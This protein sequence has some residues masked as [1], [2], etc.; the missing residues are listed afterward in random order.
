MFDV[1]SV[2]DVIQIINNNFIGYPL[3]NET[4]AL[5]D[6][7]GR[8]LCAD[9]LAHEEIPGFNRSS[10][11]GYAVISSDTFGASESLP[12]QLQLAGEIR[13]G[14]KPTVILQPGQAVYVPTGGE[15]PANADSVIMIE[16]TEDYQ[17]GFIYINKSSAPGNNVIFKGDD[18][19]IGDTVIKA[20]TVLRPQDIGAMA[21]MGYET[22]SVKQKVRVGV[23][24]TG[25][26]IIAISEKPQGSQ[27][28]DT[29]SYAL[30]AGLLKFGAVPT[31]YGIVKDNYDDIK[32]TVEKALH[33][34]DVI[35]IS[36][37][38]SVGTRDQS[39]KVINALG[40]PGI[41]V[42]GIAV[43]PGKPTILGKINGKAI[44]GLPGHPASAYTIFNIFVHHLLKVLTCMNNIPKTVVRVEMARNYPS[45]NG[46]EE[47][48]P[49]KLEEID[50]KYVAYPVFGKSGLITMLTAADG[51]V[52]IGRGCEGLDKGIQVDVIL[53]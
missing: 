45:N 29:N 15:L 42:H 41:L 2:N 33:Q 6:A 40:A 46:R 27:M 8:I 5:T 3:E 13:M 44:F 31:L 1:K 26:E 48:L 51:Y 24:S 20:G 43:K 17:D 23:I 28:R 25:D 38:S 7:L 52:H 22:I 16:Y 4:V 49:V 53:S 47:Y 50:G 14:E 11:D 35:L 9:V 10:V 39:Y 19:K 21:A 36:G 30:Y 37:G 34:S 12:A 18:V 32:A